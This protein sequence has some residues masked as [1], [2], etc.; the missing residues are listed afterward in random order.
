LRAQPGQR[1]VLK[2]Q[3]GPGCLRYDH[4]GETHRLTLDRK[5]VKVEVTAPVGDY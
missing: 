4:L 2:S 5:G 1:L 3:I